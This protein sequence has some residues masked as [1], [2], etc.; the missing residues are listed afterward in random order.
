MSMLSLW[1]MVSSCLPN[2]PSPREMSSARIKRSYIEAMK[3]KGYL[4]IGV[5]GAERKGKTTEISLSFEYEEL[6]DIAS[7]REKIVEA[8]TVFLQVVNSR[9]EESEYFVT[10]PVTIDLARIVIFGI[11][12]PENPLDFVESVRLSKGEVTY[13]TDNPDP[14]NLRL[15]TVH[16][17]SFEEA[18]A[19]VNSAEKM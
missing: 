1:L 9:P 16:E 13:S 6:M 15:V 4:A 5:G 17:E 11:S 10:Y 7:A 3:E 2:Q 14:A 8:G 18:V 19:L 12:P